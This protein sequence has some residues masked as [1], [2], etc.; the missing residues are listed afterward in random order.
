MATRIGALYEQDFYVWTRRP[1]EAL[2]R[3]RQDPP[4]RR[5]RF[6]APES[7]GGGLAHGT[8]FALA[9]IRNL[10]DEVIERRGPRLAALGQ[11]GAG[12]RLGH[13]SSS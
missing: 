7:T 2:R 8:P 13:K 5:T 11:G 9:Q 12:P 3:S 1:A 6:S 10:L 4:V